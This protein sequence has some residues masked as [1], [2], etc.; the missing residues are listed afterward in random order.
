MNTILRKGA[1]AISAMQNTHIAEA[2]PLEKRPT[3]WDVKTPIQEGILCY[4]ELSHR[5]AS[6]DAGELTRAKSVDVT[7]SHTERL[8]VTLDTRRLSGCKTWRENP[9]A[10]HQNLYIYGNACAVM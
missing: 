6:T 10:V 1:A 8:T 4:P 7:V 2:S 3:V 9:T 5:S